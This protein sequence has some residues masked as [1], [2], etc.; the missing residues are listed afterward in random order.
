MKFRFSSVLIH[1]KLQ[2]YQPPAVFLVYLINLTNIFFE[3]QYPL[4]SFHYSHIK[5]RLTAKNDSNFV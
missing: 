3:I 1:N 4:A 2:T 5:L